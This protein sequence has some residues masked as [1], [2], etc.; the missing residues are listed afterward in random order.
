[1]RGRRW[2]VVTFTLI[3]L[4]TLVFLF[5]VGPIHDQQPERSRVRVQ[6]LVL[7]ATYPELHMSAAAEAFVDAFKKKAGDEWDKVVLS[8]SAARSARAA[9]ADETGD[10]AQ[11]QEQMNSVCQEFETQQNTDILDKYAFV[12]ARPH[13]L[14][15][16]T[17]NFLHGGLV[18]LDRE[19]VVPL[20]CGIYSRGQLGPTDLLHLLSRCRSRC[21]A[22]LRVVR[23]RKLH[24]SRGRFRSGSGVDGWFS[25]ALPPDEN[26]NGLLQPYFQ[27]SL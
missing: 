6:L 9:V 23:A 16:V 12:P 13:L 10:V 4:N 24:T 11:L 27:A 15:Y 17:A 18:A 2:P 1:M 14:S 25:R 21:F 26:R 20:A 19:H 22:V 8:S 3:A 7:A 5:T